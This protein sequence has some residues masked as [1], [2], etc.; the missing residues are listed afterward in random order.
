MARDLEDEKRK[1]IEA[2]AGFD[3]TEFLFEQGYRMTIAVRCVAP[4]QD[5]PH[6]YRYELNLFVPDSAGNGVIRILG[7][8]N[9]HAPEDAKHPHDHWHDPKMNPAGRKPIG[10]NPGKAEKVVSIEALIGKFFAE[11]EKILLSQGVSKEVLN[12]NH[13]PKRGR[14]NEGPAR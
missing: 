14:K 6:G 5:C 11:A 10:V 12:M 4:N 8:D 1:Y 3:G 9:A 13:A 7:A 2:I